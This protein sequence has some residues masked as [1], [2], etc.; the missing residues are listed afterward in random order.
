MRC[1]G[2]QRRVGS[3][4]NSGKD[5]CQQN[6]GGG[7]SRNISLVENTQVIDSARRS[8]SEKRRNCAQLER[9][10]RKR[11]VV[12]PRS[13]NNFCIKD[14]AAKRALFCVAYTMADSIA[15]DASLECDDLHRIVPRRVDSG[16]CLIRTGG[17]GHAA[18]PAS[19]S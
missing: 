1:S 3:T 9:G 19:G 6:G 18:Q 15:P 17:R 11:G 13:G 10:S 14:A 4:Q 2:V 16:R 12:L 8:K 7:R 5:P